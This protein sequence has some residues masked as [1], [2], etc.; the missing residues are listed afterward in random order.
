M[1][2]KQRES[3][4]KIQP[5]EPSGDIGFIIDVNAQEFIAPGTMADKMTDRIKRFCGNHGLAVPTAH[6]EIMS[7]VARSIVRFTLLR[8][9]DGADRLHCGKELLVCESGS[10]AA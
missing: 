3:T 5:Q 7:T 4:S 9:L 10:I 1:D 6:R 2:G 8:P